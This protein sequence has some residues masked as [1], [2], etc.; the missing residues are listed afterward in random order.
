MLKTSRHKVDNSKVCLK[1]D[2]VLFPLMV[3][4]AQSKL[5][6]M[7]ESLNY[8][9]GPIPWFVSNRRRRPRQNTKI[10]GLRNSGENYY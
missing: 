6:D 10:Q 4:I 7:K 3:V 5:L 2:R 8:E 1:A 9:I